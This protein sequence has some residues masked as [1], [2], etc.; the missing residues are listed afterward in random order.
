MI[1][2]SG[3]GF[4]SSLSQTL[5]S[6]N[7]SPRILVAMLAWTTSLYNSIY[8]AQSGAVCGNVCSH[9]AG[10]RRCFRLGGHSRGTAAVRQQNRLDT[11][12]RGCINYQAKVS[13]SHY[14]DPANA[15]KNNQKGGLPIQSKAMDRKRQLERF[16]ATAEATE[17]LG[18]HSSQRSVLVPFCPPFLYDI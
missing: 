12:T 2:S 5:S 10:V 16:V 14:I 18:E 6:F 3:T 11:S 8:L 1:I 9:D 13:R 4:R 17:S 15:P 7:T